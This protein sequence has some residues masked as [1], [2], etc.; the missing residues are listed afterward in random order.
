MDAGM[1]TVDHR[2]VARLCTDCAEQMQVVAELLLLRDNVEP[3]ALEPVQVGSSQSTL[4]VA[5]SSYGKCRDVVVASTKQ[6][7]ILAHNL[8]ASMKERELDQVF[9][10]TAQLTEVV[11]SLTESST[12]AAYLIG[13]SDDRSTPSVPG[14]IDRYRMMRAK[15]GIE[16]SSHKFSSNYGVMDESEV[17]RVSSN[18]ATNLAL[19]SQACEV[20]MKRAESVGTS[21]SVVVTSSVMSSPLGMDNGEVIRRQLSACVKALQGNTAALLAAIKTLAERG[22]NSDRAKC[23]LFLKPLLASLQALVDYTS[24]PEFSGRPAQLSQ[25]ARS[26]QKDILANGMK[27]V[28]AA[29]QLM[30][31]LAKLSSD[32]ALSNPAEA[33]VSWKSVQTCSVALSESGRSLSASMRTN[34]PGGQN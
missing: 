29:I 4:T 21:S 13:L 5:T 23:A 9:D 34:A 8:R 32:P 22:D 12:Q 31:A 10:I 16:A 28:S 19:V 11:I 17:L 7:A 2:S 20:A 24:L 14:L 26:R 18:I 33:A 3:T 1:D 15:Q 25:S 27:V 30:E 6:L